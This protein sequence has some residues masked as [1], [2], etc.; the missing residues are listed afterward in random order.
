MSCPLNSHFEPCG[1]ACPATCETPYPSSPCP[2][3]CVETCQCDPGFVLDGDL[4]VPLARC[5]CVHNGD[6]YHSNQ[7][8]WADEEC[9]K[10]CVCDPP[11]H[12]VQ[13]QLASC[14]PDEYCGL[15]DG[16]RSCL[17]LLWHTCMYARGH[18]ITFDQ[19]DYSLRGTC[20]YQL[21]GICG[22]REGLAGLEVHVQTDG[23]LE[24]AFH[25]LVNVDGV[26]VRLNSKD[27]GSVEVS[28][29]IQIV[30]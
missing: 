29:S 26:L 7:L 6:R 2:L 10:R 25:V 14:G 12:Q 22:Q 23:H 21:L 5:G 4:C 30:F 24:S 13:C 15:R 17:P 27:A 16:V 11:T 18:I 3:A 28:A 9:T 20:L 1:T 19:Y 8:F